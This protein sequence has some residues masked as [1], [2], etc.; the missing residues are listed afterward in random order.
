M[1]FSTDPLIL[2]MWAHYA[3]NSGFVVGYDT[4]FLM[5]FGEDLRRVL[6]LDLAPQY[7][8]TRDSVIRLN[9]VDEERRR[10][11]PKYYGKSKTTPV[12]HHSISLLELR[13]EWQELSK[14]LFVKG[15]TWQ[16][17]REVRLLMDLTK[18]LPP[19]KCDNFGYPLHLLDIPAEAIQEVYVGFN[20][21]QD[22]VQRIQEI[23]DIG[24]GKWK[25]CHTDSHAYRMQVTST[26]ILNRKE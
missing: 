23:V 24:Q 17:E 2:I 22:K 7:T 6:Y 3:K 13:R 11:D 14:V 5:N 9:F 10:Q 20:T 26:S 12:L 25:L 8:P 21:P 18:T 19:V 16:Y 15:H 4:E 1:S